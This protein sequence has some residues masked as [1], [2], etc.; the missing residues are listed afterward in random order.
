MRRMPL[1]AED[2]EK[3]VF[4]SGAFG[5]Q[6]EVLE[7][8]SKHEPWSKIV[9]AIKSENVYKPVLIFVGLQGNGLPHF[10]QYQ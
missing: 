1:N 7:E 9:N 6:T 3:F 10:S 4:I 5:F 8:A 2:I